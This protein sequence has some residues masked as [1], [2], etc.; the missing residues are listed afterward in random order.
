MQ[1][2]SCEL[3]SSIV[4]TGSRS[5]DAVK[6]RLKQE[7]EA[8]NNEKFEQRPERSEETSCADIKWVWGSAPSKEKKPSKCNEEEVCFEEYLGGQH[9]LCRT[10]HGRVGGDEVRKR[11][12]GPDHED[13]WGCENY[14]LYL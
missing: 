1:K 13:L 3:I 9:A 10:S 4:E 7:V 6:R 11:G 5:T 2:A 14:G 8:P 12:Q